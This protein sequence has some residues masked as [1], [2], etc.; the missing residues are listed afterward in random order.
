MGLREEV[1]KNLQKSDKNSFMEFRDKESYLQKMYHIIGACMDLYNELGFGFS[2]PIYQE[3]L[4]V[5]CE[6]K[7]IPW[8][9]EKTLCMQFHGHELEKRYKADFV[10]YGDIIVE[11][12]AVSELTKE[13]RAQLF[14]Y[15][16]ITD[17]FAGVLVN[18]GNPDHLVSERYIYDILDGEYKY[19]TKDDYKP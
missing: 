4:S 16:R 2:E 10:C 12:K 1:N 3:C 19:V 9:R 7:G 11:L 17:S 18:F 14:N 5:V 6:E 8:E 15:M 13:H